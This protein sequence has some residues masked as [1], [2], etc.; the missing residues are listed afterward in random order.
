MLLGGVTV[1]GCGLRRQ[2][3]KPKNCVLGAVSIQQCFVIF[4]ENQTDVDYT[5]RHRHV[6][7]DG[8]NNENYK[9]NNND[10][11]GNNYRDNR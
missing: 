9:N 7:S 8:N 4:N 1:C 2:N 6:M 5:A 3:N 11:N 10:D